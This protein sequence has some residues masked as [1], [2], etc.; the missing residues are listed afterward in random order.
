MLFILHYRCEKLTE[1]TGRILKEYRELSDTCA[2]AFLDDDQ[3][4]WQLTT[5]IS[6]PRFPT[7]I[8]I[9][10]DIKFPGEYPF[11]IPHVSLAEATPCILPLNSQDAFA[12]AMSME[13]VPYM[14][15]ADLANYRAFPGVQWVLRR[16]EYWLNYCDNDLTKY[17]DWIDTVEGKMGANLKSEHIQPC[18]CTHCNPSLL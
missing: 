6:T 11:K 12:M 2:I 17:N 5:A 18:E 3:R 10:L 15:Q 9:T 14:M 8:Q 1:M 4:T 13:M 16:I 7:A